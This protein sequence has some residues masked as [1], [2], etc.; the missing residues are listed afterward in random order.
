MKLTKK[1]KE[2]L[3]KKRIS[4]AKVERKRMK[5]LKD[6]IELYK[7][8]IVKF[9]EDILGVELEAYQKALLRVQVP[10]GMW[11]SK[12]GNRPYSVD[13]ISSYYNMIGKARLDKRINL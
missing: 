2:K 3:R 6:N 1:Q 11:V 10:L 13:I 5:K 9:A 8:D 7:N 12:R 4:K